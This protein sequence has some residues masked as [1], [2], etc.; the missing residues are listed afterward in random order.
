M[1]LVVCNAVT[2][3][4]V[5]GRLQVMADGEYKSPGIVQERRHLFL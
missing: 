5:V 1:S 4:Q 2:C 3:V